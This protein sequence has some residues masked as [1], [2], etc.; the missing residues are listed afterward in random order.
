M[1]FYSEEYFH[2]LPIVMLVSA[3][4]V[5]TTTLRLPRSAGLNIRFNWQ[6]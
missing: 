6:K 1:F 2:D 3:M 5:A 4:F